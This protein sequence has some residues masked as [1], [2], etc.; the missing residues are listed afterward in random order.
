[1]K[2]AMWG[3]DYDYHTDK[4]FKRP[5]CPCCV[6]LVPVYRRDKNR[7]NV[8]ECISCSTEFE[9]DE[10]MQKWLEPREEIKEE[11]EQCFNCEQHTMIVY[12]IRNEVTLEWKTVYGNCENCGT[13]FIV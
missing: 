11:T 5:L 13:R 10:D 4:C 9:L 12:Y 6:D 8:A 3:T 1:M 2:K 7:P